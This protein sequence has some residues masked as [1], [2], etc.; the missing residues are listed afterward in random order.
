M[1]SLIRGDE[2]RETIDTIIAGSQRYL[3]LASRD[4][5]LPGSLRRKVQGGEG[6]PD[7]RLWYSDRFIVGD[8]SDIT[9]LRECRQI[10]VFVCDRL[11][12][13]LFMNES[14]GIVT[15]YSL[16]EA[17]G[18]TA[19]DLGVSFSRTADDSMFLSASDA[20]AA[21][22]AESRPQTDFSGSLV[23]DLWESPVKSGRGGASRDS[24]GFLDRF[25]HEALGGGGYCIACGTPMDYRRDDPFCPQCLHRRKGQPDPGSEGCYCHNCGAAAKVTC[26]VPF[27]RRCLSDTF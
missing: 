22:E 11:R 4:L 18:N 1:A 17:P 26:T 20:I 5:T 2:I 3:F 10:R 16:F 8:P 12:M 9:L 21:I 13:N 25:F 19:L 23:R 6:V 15:S 24:R 27:C 14:S 7:T